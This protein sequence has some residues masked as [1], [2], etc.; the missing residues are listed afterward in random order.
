MQNF[1]GLF[2][3]CCCWIQELPK[4]QANVINVIEA[5]ATRWFQ[6]VLKAIVHSHQ[7]K[8]ASFTHLPCTRHALDIPNLSTNKRPLTLAVCSSMILCWEIVTGYGLNIIPQV[9][10]AT[11]H[12]D[13]NT[14]TAT[15]KSGYCHGQRCELPQE[16]RENSAWQYRVRAWSSKQE[17]HGMSQ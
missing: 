11:H 4:G 17:C 10:P 12:M 8:L 14:W 1:E 3:K 7:W 5:F 6:A 9:A 15:T 13:Q 16:K 2:C